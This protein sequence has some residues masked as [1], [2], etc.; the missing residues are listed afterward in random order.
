MVIKT[1]KSTRWKRN[2][3]LTAMGILLS[4]FAEVGMFI[5]LIELGIQISEHPNFG[6]NPEKGSHS[7]KPR[8]M[9]LISLIF[10]AWLLFITII[11]IKWG[12]TTKFSCFPYLSC[13]LAMRNVFYLY[14]ICLLD[15]LKDK[16]EILCSGNQRQYDDF[17]GWKDNFH[18]KKTIFEEQLFCPLWTFIDG[19]T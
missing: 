8:I 5:N 6:L 1:E 12:S 14:L 15:Y 3:W 19:N 4:V 16:I 7:W 9:F 11:L 17:C 18:S 2:L 13:S 10:L